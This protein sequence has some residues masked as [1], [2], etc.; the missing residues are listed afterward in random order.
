[1]ELPVDI[2]HPAWVTGIATV[3]SYSLILALLTAAV[4]LIPYLIF[5]V[6]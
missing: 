4:F 3:I 2:R 6:L 5:S 1:M